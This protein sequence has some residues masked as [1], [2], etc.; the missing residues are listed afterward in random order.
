MPFLRRVDS[1]ALVLLMFV[2]LA[3]GDSTDPDDEIT[4]SLSPA[5]DTVSLRRTTQLSATV[6]GADEE[7]TWTSSNTDIATVDEYGTVTGEAVGNATITAAVT[8]EPEVNATAIITVL[9]VSTLLTLGTPLSGRSSARD[10]ETFYRVVVPAGTARLIISTSGGTGNAD[11]VARHGSP[12]S[13]EDEA[14]ACLA[15]TAG[16]DE[17]CT[18]YSPVAGTYY[19]LLYATDAYS[20]LTITATTSTTI[21]STLL[22][23]GVSVTGIAGAEGSQALYRIVVPA[24]KTSLA[25]TTSGGTGDADILVKRGTPP[26]YGSGDEDCMSEFAGTNNEN[27]TISSPAAG[28]WYITVVGYTAFSGLTLRATVSP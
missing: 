23:S 4:I 19:I 17:N 9:D 12:P 13:P 27:C 16:N 25:V 6:T 20:G 14:F 26:S 10:R 3:C 24:G 18:V 21:P 7:V 11:I 2:A 5:N 1:F 28:D 8:S 15:F 22:T